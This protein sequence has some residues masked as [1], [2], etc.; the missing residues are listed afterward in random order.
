MLSL[1]C[2]DPVCLSSSIRTC[3]VHAQNMFTC[4]VV[5]VLRRSVHVLVDIS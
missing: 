5:D 3:N 4:N 1:W 2:S